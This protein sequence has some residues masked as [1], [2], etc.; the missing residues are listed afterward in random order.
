[1]SRHELVLDHAHPH[2]QEE[3]ERTSRKAVQQVE[4]RVALVGVVAVTGRQVD[5]H[6]L[7]AAAER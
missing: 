3:G 6:R 1:M 2:G 7:A 5:V 4:D